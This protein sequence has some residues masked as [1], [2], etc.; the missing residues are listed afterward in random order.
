MAEVYIYRSLGLIA[1]LIILFGGI[2]AL[3]SLGYNSDFIW[4]EEGLIGIGSLLFLIG[5][6]YIPIDLLE[7]KRGDAPEKL[8]EYQ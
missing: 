6:F 4:V 5:I 2:A 1:V 8:T 7:E 3:F